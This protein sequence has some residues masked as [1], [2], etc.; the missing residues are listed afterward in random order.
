VS[1]TIQ[2]NGKVDSATIVESE[3]GDPGTEAC[4]ANVFVQ[5]RFPA[6]MGGGAVV[7]RYPLIFRP[8]E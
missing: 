7:V 8:V 4:V 6:P 1:F 2:P 3:L 5:M